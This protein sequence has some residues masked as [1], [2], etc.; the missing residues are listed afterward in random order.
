MVTDTIPLSESAEQ[1]GKIVTVSIA[2]M[3]AEVVKRVHFDEAIS[4]IFAEI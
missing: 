1:C 3:L 4:T 2:P